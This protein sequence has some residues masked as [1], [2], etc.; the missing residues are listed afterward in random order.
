[1]FVFTR[2]CFCCH[3][4]ELLFHC[5]ERDS[6]FLAFWCIFIY[7]HCW[8]IPKQ[9]YSLKF[10]IFLN[11][12]PTPPH[13]IEIQLWAGHINTT[14]STGRENAKNAN[15]SPTGHF[16]FSIS[17]TQECWETGSNLQGD[18]EAWLTAWSNPNHGGLAPVSHVWGKRVRERERQRERESGDLAHS[19]VCFNRIA[20]PCLRI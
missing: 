13:E 15:A 3:S 5:F 17:T 16:R 8:I 19:M 18:V 14:S 4:E 12:F 6:L 1:M 20:S 9:N 2:L 10:C 7:S 11:S